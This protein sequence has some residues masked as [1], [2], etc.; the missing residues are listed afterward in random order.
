MKAKYI[1]GA[2]VIVIFLVWGASA[3]MNTTVQYVSIEEA[4]MSNRTVQVMGKIDFDAV[5][6]NSESSLTVCWEP[7]P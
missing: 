5:N 3:F 7:S 4:A 6:Y 2:A 1:I